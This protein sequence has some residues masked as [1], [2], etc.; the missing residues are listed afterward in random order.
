MSEKFGSERLYLAVRDLLP[1]LQKSTDS[2]ATTDV[3]RTPAEQLRDKA[4][5]ME[6]L[7]ICIEELRKA[8]KEVPNPYADRK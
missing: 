6:M 1:Y 2:F 4:S 3:Y 7:D 8:F 5:R